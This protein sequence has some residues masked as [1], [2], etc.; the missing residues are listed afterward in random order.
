MSI[1]QFNPWRE[2]ERLSANPGPT[3]ADPG[4]SRGWIPVVDIWETPEAFRIDMEV[5]AVQAEDV[6]VSVDEGVLRVSGER[7]QVER[8]E[9]ERTHRLERRYGSFSRTFKLPE[10]ADEENISARVDHGVLALSIAKKTVLEPRRIEV[11][12][13]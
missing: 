2:L 13:A 3:N 7:K 5:P 8:A 6:N 1:V 12:A 4:N 11:I 10:N 9:D